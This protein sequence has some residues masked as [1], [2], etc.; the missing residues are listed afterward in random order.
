MEWIANCAE[1]IA[2]KWPRSR[3][4]EQMKQYN[5]GTPYERTF[6]D[7]AGPFLKSKLGLVDSFNKGPEVYS[8]PN[9]EAKIVA[10]VLIHNWGTRCSV[11]LKLHSNQG[12]NLESALIQNVTEYAYAKNTYSTG[13]SAVSIAFNR[14]L[15][16]HLMKVVG[17][18]QKY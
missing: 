14:T 5:S 9:Q 12:K 18:Y 3:N 17:K 13:T 15:G 11:P 6:I 7:V 16:E 10:D 1:Y 8:I 4:Q 2:A